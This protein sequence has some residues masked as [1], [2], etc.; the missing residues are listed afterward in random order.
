[1]KTRV[2]Y[3]KNADYQKFEVLQSNRNKRHKY[4]EFLVEGVR[5]INEAIKNDWKIISFIYSEDKA[6]SAWAKDVLNTVKTSINYSL[7]NNLMDD[8]SRKEDSSE[9]LAVIKMNGYRNIPVSS[10]NP[11][12]ALFDRPS[13]KGNLGTM[14]RSCDAFGV[15][16]LII[17]G[18]SVDIYDPD[19]IS[20]SM[21]SFFKVPFIKL[22]DNYKIDNYINNL[23]NDFPNIKIIGTTSH[24][25]T[26]LS[27]I[28]L[29]TPVLFL[30][31]NETDGLNRHLTEISDLMA[32]VPM[33]ADSSASSLNVS[34]AASIL[35]Y[36]TI[37]QRSAIKL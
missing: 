36:E 24:S 19:V 31:G 9:L 16:L 37:R 14:L 27:G 6:L 12:I 30:I 25:E 21:G 26:V 28:N 32:S 11:V 23:K 7:K 5:S 29:T 20:A 2:I 15:N 18:H 13:N 1:M 8:L 35:F 22:S 3:S 10:E 34:C 4:N 33:S 17:T